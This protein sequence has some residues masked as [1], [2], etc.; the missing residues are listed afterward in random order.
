MVVTSGHIVKRYDQQLGQVR[1]L[2]LEMGGLVESQIRYA[3]QALADEDM[4]LARLVLSQEQRVNELD[5]LIEEESTALVAL[6]APMGSDLRMINSIGRA[7]TDLE[8]IGD[9]AEKM[10][11]MAINL[12][13][14]SD[15]I[16]PPAGLFRDIQGMSVLAVNMLTG[17]LDAFARQDID[18]A[19]LITEGD[20]VLDNAFHDSLRRLITY[21]MEDP[22][23][24]G[25]A[26]DV[27]FILKAL[28]RIGDHAKNIAEYVSYTVYGKHV[29][30]T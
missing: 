25:C 4:E 2:L 9:E 24:I 28:E 26:I 18:S 21:M 7:V 10:A 29:R 5:I 13:E 1:S 15:N 23:I 22:R 12:H 17:A 3:T 30:H 19:N 20:T 6:R 16:T 11:R 14:R 8:R 27:L